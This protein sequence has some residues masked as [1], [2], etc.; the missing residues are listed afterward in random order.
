MGD[1]SLAVAEPLGRG[2]A[3]LLRR[4]AQPRATAARA[5]AL[6]RAKGRAHEQ[7]REHAPCGMEA[8]RD[9]RDNG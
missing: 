4:V 2:E 6:E 5:E 9:S 3:Y 8:I 1:G 7:A